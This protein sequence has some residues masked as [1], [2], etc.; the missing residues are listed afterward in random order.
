LTS[1]TAPLVTSTARSSMVEA[2]RG[3]LAEPG[4]RRIEVAWAAGI[5]ADW[6]YLIA[7]LVV[8]YRAGGALG[9][10]ILGVVRMV[11]AMVLGPL[12]GTSIRRLRGE[13]ALL[14][15]HAARGGAALL[16]ALLLAVDGPLPVVYLLAAVVAGAGA[17]VRPIQIALLP[18]FAKT[19]GEL[20]ASNVASSTGEGV[21]TFVGPLLGGAVVALAGP[22][23]ACAMVA[24]IGLG[25]AGVVAGIRAVT[26]PADA[27]AGSGPGSGNGH[28][29]AVRFDPGAGVRALRA[30]PGAALIVG[31]FFAQTFVRGLL[32]TLVVV[33]SIG[34][35]RLGE[36]GIGLLNGAMGAG[37]LAGGLLALGLAGRSRLAPAFAVALALWGLPIAVIGG[38]PFAAVAIVELFVTGLANAVLDVAGFTLLQRSVPNES[39][40]AVFGLFEGLIGLGVA[41]GSIAAP[42]LLGVLGPQGALLATGAILPVLA[43]VT[44]PRIARTDSEVVVPERQLALLR[45][46]P[47]FAPLPMTALEQLAGAAVPVAFANGETLMAQGEPG[48]RFIVIENGTVDVVG[49]G[50]FIRACGPGNGIGEIA[51][52]RRVPRTATAIARSPVT[53]YAFGTEAFLDA[54]AMP[55]S[56]AAAALLVRQRLA[57][58]PAPGGGLAA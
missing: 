55:A 7:L 56:S 20:V 51:L 25:T 12:T 1:V 8:A 23:W 33:A 5:V 13:R 57:E 46:I 18:A 42:I 53:G 14:A 45:T 11:P 19:P 35:L 54:V 43:V 58:R 10:G 3:A 2:L 37:G 38:L 15:V 32:I 29:A 28:R 6:A 21:G 30:H 49:D 22:G 47:F 4:I 36:G 40:L 50:R 27:R 26:D 9:V 44:W 24:L 48:D 52:L 41:L 39:R 16:T 34:I 31:D 17:L